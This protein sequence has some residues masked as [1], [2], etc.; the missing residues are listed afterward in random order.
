MYL[1]KK[2]GIGIVTRSQCPKCLHHINTTSVSAYDTRNT[3]NIPP[4]KEKYNFFRNSFLRY[5][6]QTVPKSLQFKCFEY[7]QEKIFEA[8]VSI[9]MILKEIFNNHIKTRFKSIQT[10][11]NSNVAFQKQSPGGVL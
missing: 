11:I 1:K 4:F 7:L 8:M 5:S 9:L 10:S 3:Y 6:S 2:D